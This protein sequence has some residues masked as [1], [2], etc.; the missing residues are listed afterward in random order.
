MLRE[1]LKNAKTSKD[2]SHALFDEI[3]DSDSW[4]ILGAEDKSQDYTY[5][6]DVE[7]GTISCV[8]QSFEKSTSKKKIKNRFENESRY[9]GSL[10]DVKI[11]KN[12]LG[13]DI[14]LYA[15]LR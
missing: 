14:V 6:V 7:G 2:A 12:E 10:G 9:Y 5:T 13:I 15:E 11:V 4:I 1:V 8:L 3:T